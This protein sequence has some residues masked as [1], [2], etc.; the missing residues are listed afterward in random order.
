[1]EMV[2]VNDK[3]EKVA[4]NDKYEKVRGISARILM[5]FAA[6]RLYWAIAKPTR[7]T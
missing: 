1:M 6:F 7:N 5:L 4:V 3:Y 2:A